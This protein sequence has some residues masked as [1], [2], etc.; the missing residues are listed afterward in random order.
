[1]RLKHGING[2]NRIEGDVIKWMML[3][4]KLLTRIN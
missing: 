4:L 3:K 2:Q 1:M